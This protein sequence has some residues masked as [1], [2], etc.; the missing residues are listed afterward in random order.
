[1][2]ETYDFSK[3]QIELY[4]EW[5]ARFA[6]GAGVG[7][8]GYLPGATTCSYGT[9]DMLISR[10]TMGDL[11]LSEAEKDEWAAVINRFQRKD[12]WYAKSHTSHSREHTTAY[13]TAAL[14]LLGRS[15]ARPFAWARTILRDEASMERWIGGPYWSIV[16]PG[17]HAV[18]GVPAALAMTG[19]APERFF[20]WYFAWL[21]READPA[22]GFWRR[23]LVHRFGLVPRPTKHD[24]GGAFHMF[25]VYERFGR[26]WRYPE[27]V[28]DESLRLQRRNGLW[29]GDT[30]YCIDLDGLYCALR[31]SRNS[32][33]YREVDVLAAAKAF[34]ATAERVLNDHDSLFVGYPNSHRLT[35][36]LSAVA[37]CALFFPELVR[38]PRPWRQSLDAAPYI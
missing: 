22:S 13:A 38:T 14:A 19:G 10:F 3:F 4:P 1:M 27:R 9:T 8:F 34:L 37:E 2:P 17:S 24:M 7:E 31:S 26:A 16:W 18:S 5:E 25:Y 23:G 29:D 21:D 30:P 36:A 33:G 28:V 6:A 20:D 32:G 35:G 15:P 11:F 12:G